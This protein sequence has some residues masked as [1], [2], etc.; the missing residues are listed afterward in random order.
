MRTTS[1]LLGLIALLACLDSTGPTA[2]QIR[3]EQARWR[4][5]FIRD[6]QYLYQQIGFYSPITGKVI[7][8]IV[9]GDT[10]RGATDTLTGD[11]IPLAWG[12]VPTVDGLF[13]T[14]LGGASDGSLT[15]VQF[16]SALGYPRQIEIAGP[17]DASG[18]LFAANLQ[19]LLTFPPTH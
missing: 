7:L 13:S 9:I 14:A 11:S 12:V 8:V 19:P 6:Y 16:D 17:P 4:G 3:A 10:V 15:A 2:S 18:S 1:L 5:Y